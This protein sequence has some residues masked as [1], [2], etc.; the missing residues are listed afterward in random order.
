MQCRYDIANHDRLQAERTLFLFV[1][2]ALDS[3]I[4]TS[5]TVVGIEMHFN[6]HVLDGDNIDRRVFMPISGNVRFVAELS[7]FLGAYL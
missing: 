2:F 7:C 6:I 3:H 1:P 5:T 4:G